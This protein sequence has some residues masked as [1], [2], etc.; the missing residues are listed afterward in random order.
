MELFI[1]ALFLLSSLAH[2]SNAWPQPHQQRCSTLSHHPFFLQNTH[3]SAKFLKS[4]YYPA[5]ALNATNTFNEI[6]LCEIYGSIPYG[7]N[8]TLTFVLWLPDQPHY[9]DRFLAVGNGGMAGYIDYVQMLSQFNTGLGVAVA[10]SDAGHSALLNNV[11]M[12]APGVYLPYLHDRD[13]VQAW[14]H[15]AISLFTPTAK[16]S[17]TTETKLTQAELNLMTN[18]VLDVCDEIDGVKDRVIEDPLKC[19]FDI[20]TLAC[21]PNQQSTTCLTPSKLASAKAIYAGPRRSDN[22][23]ELYAPFALGSEI[24]WA[25]QEGPLASAFSIPILQNLVYDDLSYD[26][27]TFNWASD[28]DTLDARAGTLIDENS[29]NLS[30]YRNCGGKLLVSQGWADP[31]NAA[32][33]PIRHLQDIQSFFH[34]DISDWYR[35]FMVPGGGHCG[36]A[37]YYPQVP[38]TY[39]VLEKLVEWVERGVPPESVLSSG[40]PDGSNTTRKLCPWPQTASLVGRDSDDAADY[41]CQ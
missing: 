7:S 3:S 2:L 12:G 35:L 25:L 31:Y 13:Q 15:D 20:D 40:P 32:E 4:T 8:N 22:G 19:H 16:H 11:G 23:K 39:H 36:A 17:N 26:A 18:A 24:E 28:V 38:A 5:K 10:S 29:P 1:L 27:N 37:S 41:V 30:T 9:N 14:I 33:L 21:K 34:G 6:P